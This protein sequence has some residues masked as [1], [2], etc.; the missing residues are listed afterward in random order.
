MSLPDP[1]PDLLARAL[2]GDRDAL[3]ALTR[4][5]WPS[6]RRVAYAELGDRALAEDACQDALMRVVRF[7][8]RYDPAR[9]FGAWLRTLVRNAAREVR[10]RRRRRAQREQAVPLPRGGD[11]ERR[12]D[13]R[14]QASAISDAS[15]ALPPRQRQLVELVDHQGLSPSEAAAELGIAPGSARS[16]LFDARRALRRRLLHASDEILDLLRER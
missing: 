5:H 9:P 1:D 4:P 16:Q 6:M 2:E 10:T 3:G 7:I 8:G 11:P 15:S 13:L 12:L 14:R